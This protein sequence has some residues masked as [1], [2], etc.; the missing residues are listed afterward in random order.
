MPTFTG[1]N[2][3]ETIVPGSVSPTVVV[4]GSP[5]SP[6]NASDTI[7][8][9]GGIDTINA[10][11]GNDFVTGGQGNDTAFLGAGSDAFFWR[12]G[13]GNDVIE[14]G[15]DFD[16]LELISSGADE[17]ISISANGGR[18]RLLRDVSNVSLDLN[19]VER[20]LINPVGGADIITVNSL[21]GTD[22]TQ[23]VIGLA[24]V[25]G[26]LVGDGVADRVEV[27]GT[28]GNDQISLGFVSGAVAVNGLSAQVIV[29]QRDAND[30]LT[31]NGL[32]GNDT[33]DAS[34]VT[35]DDDLS[36]VL[37]G[38]AGNDTL[39]GSGGD[40]VLVGGSGND[41][42]SSNGGAN[43]AS[44][45]IGDD[46]FVWN[47]G[48]G[49]GSV[50]G[51]SGFDTLEFNGSNAADDIDISLSSGLARVARE[52]DGSVELRSGV[53]AV[54][55]DT[56]AGDDDVRIGTVAGT[57]VATITVNLG[58][59]SDFLDANGSTVTVL[60]FGQDD[61]DFLKGGGGA[62]TLD[63][64]S[65]NDLLFGRAGDDTFVGGLGDDG[66][67]G[68]AGTDTAMFSGNRA[69]Y[70]INLLADGI[71]DVVDQRSGQPFGTES[72][73]DVERLVFADDTFAR[74]RRS[75]TWCGGTAKAASRRRMVIS[76]SCRPISRSAEAAISTATATATSC[77]VT[78]MAWW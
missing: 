59:G 67:N 13:D 30:N 44:L 22:V 15:L 61:G 1:T 21:A 69:S 50:F 37:N 70:Q 39:I 38:G 31:I 36:L 48:D 47:P 26:G 58:S 33:L 41:I 34:A 8:A 18:V 57:D 32:D 9:G 29:D 42:V 3:A 62:D 35:A 5:A 49:F 45:G 17:S 64:G 6:S 46:V 14:G 40:D 51:E 60:A 53:E 20:L 68:G 73:F 24:G 43:L 23:V 76:A 66:I 78:T 56:G 52:D 25:A 54:D 65:G 11:G 12:A 28:G 4:S 16:T 63:G 75:E 27:N 10:G 74:S 7:S 72:M 19:D 2:S 71:V 55:L 77:G